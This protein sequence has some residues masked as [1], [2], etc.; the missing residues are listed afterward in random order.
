MSFLWGIS[1]SVNLG[2]KSTFLLDLGLVENPNAVLTHF[3]PVHT[4]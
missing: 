4:L 2:K 1:S 3:R